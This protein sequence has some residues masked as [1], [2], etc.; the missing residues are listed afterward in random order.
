MNGF[1]NG[2][3]RPARLPECPDC[4]PPAQPGKTYPEAPAPSPDNQPL[5]TSP[6]TPN[7]PDSHPESTPDEYPD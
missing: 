1:E 6:E 5:R 7:L 3:P 2:G 4:E